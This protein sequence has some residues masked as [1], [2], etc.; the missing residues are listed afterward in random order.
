M[1][2]MRIKNKIFEKD[3][4]ELV[5]ILIAL[6]PMFT[7]VNKY[8]YLSIFSFM[9]LS[10]IG[11]VFFLKNRVISQQHLRIGILLL[12]IC[13]YLIFSY[14][15]SKQPITNLFT[16]GFLRN[17]GNFFFSYSPF[18]IL[19]VPFI[20]YRK[21]LRI[22]FWFLFISFIVFAV[23]GLFE[24]LNGHHFLTVRIDDY[25]VGSMLVTLNNSHN[26]TGSVFAIVSIFAVAF[27]FKS[28]NKEKIAYGLISVLCLAALAITKSRG[29]L[30]AFVVGVMYVLLIGSGSFLKFLRNILILAIASVPLVYITG[31]FGRIMQIFKIYDQSALTRLSLWSKAISLFKQSPIIGIGFGRYNDVLWNF[32][33]VSLSGNPGIIASYTSS[34][35]VFNDTN[36]HSSYFHFLAETG[37]IGLF[38][39]VAFWLLCFIL[40]FQAYRKTRDDFSKKV[41]LAV[42]GGIVTLFALALT[43]N[44]M[45]APTV[46]LCLA[47]TTSLAIGLSGKD[48][49]EASK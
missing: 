46:M 18:F 15:I 13:F 9:L 40:I 38:L 47:L 27:F 32:D 28:N 36:A 12:L 7:L 45:T 22:Y 42:T 49:S 5:Y 4:K 3:V 20:D 33:H 21:A 16:Y 14:I 41:Y 30:I 31:T 39:V 43:E 11:F 35:Y 24:Y 10:L 6:I 26:A 8:P 44:Y 25:Y 19:A 34:N 1:T 2:G 48:R 29:S 17:D 23:I 37:I